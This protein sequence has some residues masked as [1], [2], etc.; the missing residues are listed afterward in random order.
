MRASHFSSISKTVSIPVDLGHRCNWRTCRSRC[1]ILD[2]SR[3]FHR[4]ILDCVGLLIECHSIP[5]RLDHDH[6]LVTLFGT[7]GF[8][9]EC[10]LFPADVELYDPNYNINHGS[11]GTQEWPPK[12]EWYLMTGIHLEYHEVHRYERIPDSHW[13]VFRNSY[14]TMDQLIRQLQMHG[15]REQGIMIQLIIDYLWHDA[16]ACSEITESLIKLMGANQTRDGWNTWVTHLIRKTIKDS[17]TA[18]FCKHEHVHHGYWSLLV[19]DILQIPCISWDLH[20]VQHR[21]VG[22][23]SSDYFHEAVEFFIFHRL[24]CLTGEL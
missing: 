1:G 8:E 2:T 24:L 16:H 4:K 6:D 14:W 13:D 7:L 3:K 10:L 19:E 9:C 18:S 12:N 22:I 23:H 17:S 11:G 20:G 21:N 15:S 5:L